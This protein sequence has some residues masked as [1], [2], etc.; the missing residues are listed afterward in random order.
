MDLFV[1]S[2]LSAILIATLYL[3][4]KYNYSHW[5]RRGIPYIE[6]SFPFGNF[7]PL[8]KGV[9]SIGQN[10]H[11]LYNESTEPVVGTFLLFRPILL[12]RDAKIVRD[13]LIKDFQQFRD[14]GFH[15][16]SKA[17]PLA[18][19]LFWS[20][21]N[22]KEMRSK[23][24]PAFTS[25][26]LKGMF[27][28][29]VHCAKPLEECI[30]KFAVAGKEAEVRE[31]FSRFTTNVIASIGFGI[32]IDSFKDPKN[33]FREKSS[34]IFEP[35][36]RNEFRFSMSFLSPFLTKL[37]RI[38][39]SDK[40]ITDFMI[41]IV[42]NNLDYREKYNIVRK[43]FFQLLMQIRNGGKVKDD[44]EEWNTMASNGKKSL[45]IS[46]MAAQA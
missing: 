4:V 33:E 20:D 5:K 36:I 30:G 24:S 23:L 17:D 11:D 12:I 37:L 2:A 29:I 28:T 25:G 39:S 35:L 7:G 13:V 3:W 43:D 45:S 8:C 26:K 41:E 10:L 22:W 34:R 9:R 44:G 18:D 40:D 46:E 32:E 16:D 15:L 42:R 31:I 27:D 19:N 14:R 1:V 6:P 21:E 38:R